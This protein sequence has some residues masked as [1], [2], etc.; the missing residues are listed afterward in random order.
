MADQITVQSMQFDKDGESRYV[1]GNGR[2]WIVFVDSGGGY[3]DES[4]FNA[5]T[6]TIEMHMEGA[7]PN[8]ALVLSAKG[9]I[10]AAVADLI[11]TYSA[12]GVDVVYE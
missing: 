10:D 4:A 5:V 2:F 1:G 3:I 8:R 12:S 6:D 7:S 9:F 11:S